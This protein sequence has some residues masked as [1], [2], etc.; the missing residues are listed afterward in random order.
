MSGLRLPATQG[1]GTAGWPHEDNVLIQ[2]GNWGW[3]NRN[4]L[5]LA[6]S[7][8]GVKGRTL[9]EISLLRSKSREGGQGGR[10][11]GASGDR[12][13]Q[14]EAPLWSPRGSGPFCPTS[15]G[16]ALL[17][18]VSTSALCLIFSPTATLSYQMPAANSQCSPPAGGPGARLPAPVH[19]QR[20]G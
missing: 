1:K 8:E 10:V 2:A 5:E 20:A 16:A 3:R 12:W 19:Q 9:Q 17:I 7:K 15:L 6:G 4:P 13:T 11:G 18:S 14:G